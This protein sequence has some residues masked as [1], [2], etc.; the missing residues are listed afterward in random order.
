MVP[1]GDY[2]YMFGTPNTR[3]GAIGLARVPAAEVL[4]T[5][6]YQYWQNGNWTPVGGYTAATP[7]VGRPGR[8]IVRA[9]R[10]GHRQMADG[11]P[12]HVQGGHRSA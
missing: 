3:L 4:N 2:V 6:A 10:R 9:L 5:T 12:R 11:V 8:R 7:I 1:H